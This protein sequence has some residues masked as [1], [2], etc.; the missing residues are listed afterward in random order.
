[1]IAMAT[2]HQRLQM[3]KIKS[4]IFLI[5]IILFA[6][7]TAKMET[8]YLADGVIEY[9]DNFFGDKITVKFKDG[10]CLPNAQIDVARYNAVRKL[11][12]SKRCKVLSIK[13][14][15]NDGQLIQ[16]LKGNLLDQASKGF[17][18]YLDERQR[19]ESIQNGR[20][21]PTYNKKIDEYRTIKKYKG[22]FKATDT[23]KN[24]AKSGGVNL[25]THKGI[26]SGNISFQR[27]GKTI[28]PKIQ[29]KIINNTLTGK[30]AKINFTGNLKN[31][32]IVGSYKNSVCSG[33]FEAELL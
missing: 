33:T 14:Y 23:H 18:K 4:I 9:Q 13:D 27:N 16:E 25:V 11:E 17:Y 5:T 19:I 7:C 20:H 31:N 2:K 3:K 6:G 21:T 10:Y 1:M 8:N 29:G 12:L 15:S 22:T 30:T 24:C 26:L 28:Y 32:K